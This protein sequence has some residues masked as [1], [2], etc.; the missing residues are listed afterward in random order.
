[1]EKYSF[2]TVIFDLDGVI[3]RTALVHASAWKAVFDEYLRLR[4]KRD[5]EPFR[6]FTHEADYL[7]YVDGKPRYQGVKSFLESRGVNIPYGDPSDASDKESVCGI[8]NRKNDMFR[9]VLKKQ[10]A[11]I[12]QSSVDFILSLKQ[13]GIKV[14]VASSSKNCKYILESA[15]I[16]DLFA[17]RVDG[18]VSAE[19]GLKGKP[20]G[21]IF[22][23]AARNLGG[24]PPKTVVVEDATSGVQAGRN[25]GFGFVLGIAREN[26][27]TELMENGAD[28]VVHDLADIDIEQIEKWF[29]RQ[30]RPLTVSWDNIPEGHDPSGV[31]AQNG[32]S[33]RI[34][35]FYSKTGKE[36]FV[37]G[38][39][40]VFFLDYDGTLSPIVERPEL[41]E[42]YCKKI[43]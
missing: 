16:E 42:R 13:A 36:A 24:V 27:E 3:T 41:Y 38:K 5:G 2:D 33:L 4:E 15:G 1:M 11:E 17:T 39:R 32:K 9:E 21:D 7:P 31:K 20:E 6:E 8:G 34:N 26:N 29:C 25:G 28:I 19:L 10:G 37:S 23:T 35:H 30:P 12:F 40:L 43:V 18:V 22:V 14:G